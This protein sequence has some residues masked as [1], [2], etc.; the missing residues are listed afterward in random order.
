M[1]FFFHVLAERR[2]PGDRDTF[3]G[4][5]LPEAGP[6]LFA[7][8]DLFFAG[9]AF[10]AGEWTRRPVAAYLLPVLIVLAEM[11]FLM[12]WSPSWLDP[13]IIAP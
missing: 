1:V 3:L 9:I 4:G 11:F 12:E 10:A 8:H 7:A 6:D 2:G 5:Q 13:R